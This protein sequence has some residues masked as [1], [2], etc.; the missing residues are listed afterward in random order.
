MPTPTPTL[1][2]KLTEPK[3]LAIILIGI[4]IVIILL[5][6]IGLLIIWF[7]GPKKPT[8]I[9][10][11]ND[12][13]PGS[14]FTKDRI[15]QSPSYTPLPTMDD[16]PLQPFHQPQPPRQP[17]NELIEAILTVKQAPETIKE[18]TYTIKKAKTSIGR[19]DDERGIFND[20]NLPDKAISRNHAEIIYQNRQFFVKDLGSSFGTFVNG[21]QINKQELAPLTHKIIISFSKK[22]ELQFEIPN[23]T[24]DE[25][26]HGY[27]PNATMFNQPGVDVNKTR[28]E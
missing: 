26:G 11:Q 27:D 9:P 23:V 28:D 24:E 21:R 19:N 8:F 4:V 22:I 3:N 7:R 10:G 17:Q 13:N 16:L 1:Q 6:I 15:S 12:H 25:F 14:L 2:D 18:K 20:I 5:I